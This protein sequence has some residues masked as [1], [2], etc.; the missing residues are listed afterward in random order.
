MKYALEYDPT[1]PNTLTIHFNK[2][3]M[4]SSAL[5]E[6][7]IGAGESHEYVAHGD[8]NITVDD[9]KNYDDDTEAIFYGVIK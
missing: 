4:E 2:W 3:L 5:P 9:A 8:N 6:K 7:G 1:D